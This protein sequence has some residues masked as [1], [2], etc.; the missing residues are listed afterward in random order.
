MPISMHLRA[1]I[2]CSLGQIYINM[3]TAKKA[4]PLLV[5]SAIADIKSSTKETVALFTL[6][7]QLV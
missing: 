3:P 5:Q 2:T 7:E 1:M 6:A 4:L